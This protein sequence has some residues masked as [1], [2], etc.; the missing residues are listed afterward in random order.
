MEKLLESISKN[1]EGEKMSENKTIDNLMDAFAGESQ[2][3]RKYMAYAKKAEK[4]A[5]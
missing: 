3:N 1:E 5:N 4:K 2:A